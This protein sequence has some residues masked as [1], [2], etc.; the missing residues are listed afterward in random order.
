MTTE[1]IQIIL[2]VCIV[3]VLVVDILNIR[4]N[5]QLQLKIDSCADLHRQLLA[6]VIEQEDVISSELDTLYEDL[7]SNKVDK[8]VM[9]ASELDKNAETC[10]VHDQIESAYREWQ[11]ET[12]AKIKHI[13]RK[14]VNMT[15]KMKS[16]LDVDYDGE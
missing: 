4:K 8:L 11:A 10:P 16:I 1:M 12:A 15:S 2:F 6:M 14:Q 13:K 7:W 9:R 5:G 3:I